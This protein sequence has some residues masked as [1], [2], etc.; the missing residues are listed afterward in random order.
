MASSIN[1]LTSSGGGVVTTADSSG[2][3]NLQSNSTTIAAV[4]STGLS[5]TGSITAT[6][7]INGTLGVGQTWQDLTASRST[8]TVNAGSFVI[9]NSY[10]IVTV[11]TTSFMSIGASANT[12][13][14]S[15]TATGVGSGTGTARNTY[16]NTTGNPIQVN[17]TIVVSASGNALL[18]VD[19]VT[20]GSMSNQFGDR[21]LTATLNGVVPNQ[22]Y[23]QVTSGTISVWAEL[24]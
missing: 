9:G 24:R 7:Q 23:Y 16:R 10:T 3:L 21:T 19:G 2:V 22:S 15:F 11:G 8:S 1:A 5:V 6:G 4:S 12:V 17:T 18:Q 13:G 14:V 20:V